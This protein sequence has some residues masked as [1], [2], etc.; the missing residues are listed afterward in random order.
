MTNVFSEVNY[1]RPKG[2]KILSRIPQ[3]HS[4]LSFD[5]APALEKNYD[6][7]C[8]VDTN[9]KVING[10]NLSVVGIVTFQAVWVPDPGGLQKYW[11]FD[12]PFCLEFVSLRVNPENFGW[13]AALEQLRLRDR[14]KGVKQIGMIV[15]SDLGIIH[16][17]N[18]RRKPVF[19]THFLPRGVQLLYATSDAG[20][21][22]VLN[23]A[24]SLADSVA[25]QSIDAVASGAAPFSTKSGESRYY[26]SQRTIIP[27]LVRK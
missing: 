12:C 14:F 3:E 8:A 9:T 21:E 1:D 22:N 25:S 11:Q 23:F 4:D 13:I 6:F 5:P 17:Y 26:E 24:I 27:N 15:D 20:K 2:P 19:D 18:E 16:D 10:K 7:L